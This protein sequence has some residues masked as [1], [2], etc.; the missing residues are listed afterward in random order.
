MNITKIDEK[1][2]KECLKEMIPVFESDITIQY[3]GA[4]SGKK[5][6]GKQAPPSLYYCRN[7]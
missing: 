7:K 6:Y 5:F 1:I 4:V 2:V 3:N